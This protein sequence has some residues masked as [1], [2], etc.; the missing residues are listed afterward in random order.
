M[1]SSRAAGPAPTPRTSISPRPDHVPHGVTRGSPR[2]GHPPPVER[3]GDDPNLRALV[4]AETPVVTIFG[5][6]W[7]LHVIEVLGAT[8]DENL[9]M[10]ADSVAFWPRSGPARSVV[11]RRALLR[12]LRAAVRRARSGDP[13]GGAAYAGASTLVLCDTNGGTLTDELVA[14]IRTTRAAPTTRVRPRSPGESTSINDVELAVANS[15]AAVQNG[16]R[17]VQGTINGYGERCGNANLV[18]ILANLAL[19]T[20][21]EGRNWPRTDSAELT[22]LSRLR[23]RDRQHRPRRSPALRR[24]VRVRFTSGGVHGAAVAKVE[25]SY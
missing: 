10:I 9:A 18:S 23:R 2:S 12:R 24:P 22:E 6:S 13:P 1:P 19:K 14:I 15:L 17:H 3:P 25:R 20:P 11:R 8:P 5:K 16:I 4:A 7:L 21:Y